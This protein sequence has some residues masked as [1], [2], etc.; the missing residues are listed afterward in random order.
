M[1]RESA[2]VGARVG[3]R[4][5][6]SLFCLLALWCVGLGCWS[7]RTGS[8]LLR[9]FFSLSLLFS[10]SFFFLCALKFL[11][12]IS[13][14]GGFGL[15]GRRAMIGRCFAVR[16]LYAGFPPRP[17]YCAIFIEAFGCVRVWQGDVSAFMHIHTIH[18]RDI[19]LPSKKTKEILDI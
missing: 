18:Q 13:C 17:R 11:G 19:G 16:G 10:L 8:P 4:A 1:R 6:P 3:V 2:G 9:P 12:L 14:A 5:S 7:L 15:L